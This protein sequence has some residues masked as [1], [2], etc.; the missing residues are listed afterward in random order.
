LFRIRGATL[1]AVV[2]LSYV[3]ICLNAVSLYG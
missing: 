3:S 2:R 1:D